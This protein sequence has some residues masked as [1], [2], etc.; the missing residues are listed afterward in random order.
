MPKD[1]H[2]LAVMQQ[3]VA[4]KTDD[5]ETFIDDDLLGFMIS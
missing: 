1:D 5:G 4:G 2:Q 3:E